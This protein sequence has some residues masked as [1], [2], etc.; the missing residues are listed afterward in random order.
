MTFPWDDLRLSQVE[1]SASGCPDACGADV[2]SL[3]AE[4]RRRQEQV[5]I[6]EDVLNH[7]A[8]CGR[9]ACGPAP[10]ELAHA[11]TLA[12]AALIRMSVVE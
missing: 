9:A 4:V 1:E 12:D 2:V 3:V 11:R 6:A 7:I 8:R 5:R 10:R